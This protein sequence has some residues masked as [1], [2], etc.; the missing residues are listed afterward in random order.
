VLNLTVLLND[1]IDLHL[2]WRCP[3]SDNHRQSL[4]TYDTRYE[5]NL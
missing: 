4:D 1:V 3:W 2:L 5:P